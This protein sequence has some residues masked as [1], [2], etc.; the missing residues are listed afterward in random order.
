GGSI[1]IDLAHQLS[2]K[3]RIPQYSDDSFCGATVAINV[4]RRE[5]PMSQGGGDGVVD[6][7]GRAVDVDDIGV[8]FSQA[9][10]RSDVY[11]RR[12]ES[13]GLDDAR[14]GVAG[15]YVRSGHTGH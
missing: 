8:A 5:P 4:Y 15:E 12:A 13:P 11:D 9:L 7:L 2:I 3:R 6:G 10:A 14:A 1:D